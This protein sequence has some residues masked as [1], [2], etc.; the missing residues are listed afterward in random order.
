MLL[1]E[2]LAVRGSHDAH[3]LNK[4]KV[5]HIGGEV[6]AATFERYGGNQRI[7]ELKA[8]R[9]RIPMHQVDRLPG[10]DRRHRQD[11]KLILRQKASNGCQ[12]I[13]IGNALVTAL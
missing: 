9:E 12:A 11:A 2:G 10:R 13:P 8:M 4:R 3:G 7:S 6:Q 1:Y 5:T